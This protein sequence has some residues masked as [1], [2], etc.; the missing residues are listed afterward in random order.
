MIVTLISQCEKKALNRTRRVLDSF[1]NRIGTNVWQT[2]ITQEGL[3]AV[4]KLLRQT[5]SKNTAVSCHRVR[6]YSRTELVWVVGNRR[7]FNA[8]GVVA[9]NWTR[10]DILKLDCEKSWKNA[11]TIQVAA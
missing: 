9:T 10:K 8:E 7:K 3:D 5:A 1:A 11:T 4:R 6:G 2:V